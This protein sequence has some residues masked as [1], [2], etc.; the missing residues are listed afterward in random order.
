MKWHGY[1]DDSVKNWWELKDEWKEIETG[2]EG[3]MI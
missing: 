3:L 1:I 2:V